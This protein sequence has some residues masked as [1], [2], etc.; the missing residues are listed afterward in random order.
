MEKLINY[1]KNQSDQRKKGTLYNCIL[2]KNLIL[3]P[4]CKLTSHIEL[5]G[6]NSCINSTV[7][8]NSYGI[9]TLKKCYCTCKYV[10]VYKMCVYKNSSK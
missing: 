8:F 10:Y 9:Y 1:E 3:I 2:K 4:F 6:A 7:I 5:N